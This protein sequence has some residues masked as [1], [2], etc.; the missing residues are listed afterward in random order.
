MT[1]REKKEDGEKG[2]E[3]KGEGRRVKKRGREEPSH[4]GRGEGERTKQTS[5]AR[6]LAGQKEG[7]T[8]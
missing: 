4:G 6:S 1:G 7:Q 8:V 2:R 5:C 3:K